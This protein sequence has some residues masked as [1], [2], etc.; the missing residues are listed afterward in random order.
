MPAGVRNN[1]ETLKE[2]GIEFYNNSDYEKARVA[3]IEYLD[4]FPDDVECNYKLGVVYSKIGLHKKS[5]DQFLKTLV[6]D[7]NHVKTYY[8][9][10]VIY[11]TDGPNYNIDKAVFFFNKYLELDPSSPQRGKIS[12]W[13]SRY[14]K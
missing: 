12:N 4:F 13:L 5:R 14:E 1:P 3:L 10:G 11:S 8:N 6:L 7:R 2:Q 9:L